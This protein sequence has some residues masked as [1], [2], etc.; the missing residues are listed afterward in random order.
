M[1]SYFVIKN[2]VYLNYAPN[3]DKCMAVLKLGI[4]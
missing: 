2:A 1:T 3:K 4:N